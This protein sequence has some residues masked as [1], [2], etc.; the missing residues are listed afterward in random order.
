M[1]GF[2]FIITLLIYVIVLLFLEKFKPQMFYD[3]SGEE[4]KFD[5]YNSSITTPLTVPILLTIIIFSTYLL[6]SLLYL[7]YRALSR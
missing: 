1:F 6:T 3:A 2:Q 5:M 4:K 7:V